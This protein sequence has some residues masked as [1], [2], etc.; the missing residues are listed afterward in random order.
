VSRISRGRR[1]W[2]KG[3]EP[4]PKPAKLEADEAEAEAEADE[5][6]EVALKLD[7]ALVDPAPGAA[8]GAPSAALI[9]ASVAAPRVAS[10]V[11]I[12]EATGSASS[13]PWK[14]GAR[15]LAGNGAHC[16]L[17][18][19]KTDGSAWVDPGT[20]ARATRGTDAELP[21]SVASATGASRACA[22]A[23]AGTEDRTIDAGSSDRVN[24]TAAE[25]DE[26]EEDD[27]D[28]DDNDPAGYD[29][30]AA[31][32]VAPAVVVLCAPARTLVAGPISS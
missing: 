3:T 16:T 30:G 13:T 21:R 7:P 18:G 8:A 24:G 32:D 6:E 5:A 22:I 17:G 1:C 11:T 29:R 2:I 15:T 12:R 4:R 26:E 28:D 23:S 20:R 9:S 27:D 19:H 31:L 25:E 14:S 10:K